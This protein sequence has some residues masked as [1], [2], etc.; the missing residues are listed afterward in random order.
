MIISEGRGSWTQKNTELEST[1]QELSKKPEM[2]E[3]LSNHREPSILEIL[4][5]SKNKN[6]SQPA[7]DFDL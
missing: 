5:F 4:F 3:R 1:I 2:K 6:G 7:I